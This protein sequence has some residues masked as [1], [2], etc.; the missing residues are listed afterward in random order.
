LYVLALRGLSDWAREIGR[1]S[2]SARFAKRAEAA[3]TAF[4]KFFW[5]EERGVISNFEGDSRLTAD[6]NLLAVIHGIVTPAR[7][8][9]IM[10]ALRAG[11]LWTPMPGRATWPDYPL[12]LKS[13]T[14]R[15]VHTEDYHDS[16][17]WGWLTAAAAMAEQ[18]VGNCR[19]YWRIM[20]QLSEQIVNDQA[21]Y[22]VLELD[23]RRGKLKP[24]RRFT[25]K[26]EKPFSWGAA[27]YLKA[28]SLGC[29]G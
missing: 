10:R 26:S 25:Y 1:K 29:P 14:V 28:A 13:E 2:E 27:Y 8:E 16:M 23:P 12:S 17:Y 7:A 3:H 20:N 21:V 4:L 9:Q 19:G 24:V 5:D 18:S 22:E 15:L 6:A 11:P